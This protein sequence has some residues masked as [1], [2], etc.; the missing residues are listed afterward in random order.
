M[1]VLKPQ[2]PMFDPGLANYVNWTMLDNKL[3]SWW[4]DK[5]K[6]AKQTKQAKWA[7]NV[8]AQN[9]VDVS[10]PRDYGRIRYAVRERIDNLL[11]FHVR[12]WITN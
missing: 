8:R 12:L 10:A 5:L 3:G 6:R 9:M 7:V 1:V 4:E 2:G 11:I